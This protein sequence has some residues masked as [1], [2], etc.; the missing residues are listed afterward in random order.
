MVSDALFIHPDLLLQV[1]SWV[2]W[3]TKQEKIVHVSPEQDE[4]GLGKK[5]PVLEARA[6]SVK[7]CA[8]WDAHVPGRLFAELQGV[9]YGG[10]FRD[11]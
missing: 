6:D 4:L 5:Q 2:V 9:K 1:L 8:V 3:K 7:Y 11:C 10:H